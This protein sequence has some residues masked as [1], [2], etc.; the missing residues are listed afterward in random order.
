MRIECV[1]GLMGHAWI[2][3]TQVNAK[4]VN[5]DLDRA[6]D[7]LMSEGGV[8]TIFLSKQLRIHSK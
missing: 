8:E 6:T 4:I 5:E 2:W 3:S 7:V 1:C